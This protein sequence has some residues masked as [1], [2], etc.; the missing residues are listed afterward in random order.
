[1]TPQ[2]EQDTRAQIADFLPDAI[3]TALK[4]YKNFYD[5]EVVFET[6]KDFSAHHAACKAAIAHIE[7][8]IK[9]A[10]WADLPDGMQEA[11]KDMQ[12]ALLL[13]SAQTELEKIKAQEVE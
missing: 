1:M 4:S 3:A 13:A 5:S 7:L 2:I 6:A 11:D 9:L 12:L 8:L 10:R